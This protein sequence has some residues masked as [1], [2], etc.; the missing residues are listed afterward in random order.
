MN[1]RIE[2]RRFFLEKNM[3]EYENWCPLEK[4]KIYIKKSFLKA[5]TKRARLS[6]ILNSKWLF[7]DIVLLS[8]QRTQSHDMISTQKRAA[9]KV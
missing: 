4:S 1:L 2:Q 8:L 6:F 5:I 9:L 3:Q 7:F